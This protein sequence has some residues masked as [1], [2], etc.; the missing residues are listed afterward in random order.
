MLV[1]RTLG[2]KQNGFGRVKSVVQCRG[3]QVREGVK[4][5]GDR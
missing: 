2:S 3:T 1:T 4:T 5:A